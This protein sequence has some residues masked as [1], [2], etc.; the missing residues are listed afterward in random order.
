[1]INQLKETARLLKEIFGRHGWRDHAAGDLRLRI[2][3]YLYL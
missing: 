3:V 1:M 2:I